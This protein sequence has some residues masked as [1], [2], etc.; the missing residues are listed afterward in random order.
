MVETP[1]DILVTNYSMLNAMLMREHEEAIFEQTRDWLDASPRNVF[2]LV[3]DELHLYRGTQG[4]EVAMVVRN[5]LGR[6]GL[7]PASPQLRI[8]ATSASLA[9][10][11]SGL[12]YLEQFFGVAAGLVLRHGGPSRSRLPCT[13][14]ARSRRRTQRRDRHEPGE[15]SRADRRRVHRPEDGRIGRE[16]PRPR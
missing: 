7:E 1:P 15:L 5:L 14:E 4:S 3:V 12:E 6:L 9:A 16:P 13:H 2:T 11:S 10:D 8:I